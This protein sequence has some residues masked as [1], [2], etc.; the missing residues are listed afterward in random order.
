MGIGLVMIGLF[1]ISLKDFHFQNMIPQS[2]R[3]I[4]RSYFLA[5]AA[6]IASSIYSVMDKVGVQNLHPV[7][8]IWF[9]NLWMT[10]FMGLY[11]SFWREGSFVKVW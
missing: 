11:L 8:Y 6:S 1:V 2:K 5:L 9:I 10:I 4:A 7:F 3:R